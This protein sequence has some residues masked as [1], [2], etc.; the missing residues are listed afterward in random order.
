MPGTSSDST[1]VGFLLSG[2]R[3]RART[4]PTMPTGMLTRKIQRQLPATVGQVMYWRMMPPST[5]PR[6]EA[7]PDT[8]PHT[9]MA[10]PRLWGGKTVAMMLSVEGIIAAPP[11]PCTTRKA[12]SR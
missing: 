12:I 4:T 5:G 1:A 9:P 2:T 11:M 6:P 10:A 8:P 3:R 7:R